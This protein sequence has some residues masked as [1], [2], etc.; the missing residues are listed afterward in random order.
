MSHILVAYFSR[1][2][3]NCNVGNITKG[4][5]AVVAETI[6][7]Y[8]CADLFEIKP[9]NKYP[10]NY[11]ECIEIAKNEKFA[12]A[13]PEFSGDIDIDKYNIVFIGYPNWWGDMPMV[14]YTFLER[15]DFSDKIIIPF[16]T[17]EGSGIGSTPNYIKKVC[18]K[19]KLLNGIA[20]EGHKAN[21]AK[22][23]IKDWVCG[24]EI[25]G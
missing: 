22:N 19:A 18:P 15:Y 12:N 5:T 25:L 7:E 1:T 3:E 8:M 24:V 9:A 2:G 23:Q 21:T 10:D 16:C 14:V 17:H 4:N 11:M 13:R 20:I 6:L